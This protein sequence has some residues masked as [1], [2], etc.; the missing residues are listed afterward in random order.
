MSRSFGS[1]SGATAGVGPGAAR[2]PR[3]PF[4]REGG[5]LPGQIP[6]RRLAKVETMNRTIAPARDHFVRARD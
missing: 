6:E 2:P 1:R 4:W 3:Q 5:A